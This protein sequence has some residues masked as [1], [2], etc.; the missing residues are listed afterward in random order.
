MFRRQCAV[1]IGADNGVVVRASNGFA[2]GVFFAMT[3]RVES[4][5]KSVI[6]AEFIE[7]FCGIVGRVVIGKNHLKIGVRLLDD[8]CLKV[9]Q[10]FGFVFAADN[11]RDWRFHRCFFV[12][13]RQSQTADNKCNDH[14]PIKPD[15]NVCCDG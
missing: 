1:G 6:L 12:K 7:N 8:C 10:I 13:M 3:N 2:Q 15:E 5:R 4:V 14:Q 11:E 9:R